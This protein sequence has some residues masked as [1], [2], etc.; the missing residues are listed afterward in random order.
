ME[1]QSAKVARSKEMFQDS[2]NKTLVK[3]ACQWK[4]A[5]KQTLLVICCSAMMIG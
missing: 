4:N 2:R 3:S 1:I 5:E